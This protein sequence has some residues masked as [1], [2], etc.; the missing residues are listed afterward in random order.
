MPDANRPNIVLIHCHDL[1]TYLNCY[2]APTVRSPH[3]DALAAD[4][5]LFER[6]YCTA[7]QCSP[8]RASL[9]TGR[10]PHNNG[11]MGLTHAE[12]AWDFNPG[13]KHLATCLGE[14]GYQTI[15][16]GAT[17]EGRQ[18]PAAYGYQ[19]VIR[20]RWGN[21]VADAAT[22]RLAELAENPPDAPFYLY[23]GFMEPHRLPSGK[24]GELPGDHT[25]LHPEADYGPDTEL[26]VDVPG[27]L[28]DTPGTREE[29]AEL[30]A[31]I[32]W[33]DGQIGRILD[34]VRQSSLND[35]TLVVFT[36]DHGYAMPRAK[37]SLYDPGIAIALMM[38]LPSREG[39]HGGRRVGPMISNIDVM[40]TLLD[41]LGLPV[42]DGVQGV[43][44]RPL[45]DAEND[46]VPRETF[47]GE[48]T[49]HDYYDPK[50]CI[51]TDRYKLIANFST[52]PFFM[53]P[54]QMW[55][56]RSDTVVPENHAASYHS[57]I[58]FYDL[59]KD[60]WELE[61]LA[62]AEDVA[63]IRTDLMGRLYEHMVDTSDPILQGA[64]ACPQ[65]H[66]TQAMLEAAGGC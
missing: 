42:P 52:A 36:T 8:S 64:V 37:C 31:M 65:H 6:S 24:G 40:P 3:L 9:F 18:G 55:R 43:S 7:P 35:N 38:R 41:L 47:F 20:A 49:Y 5:V 53:D 17:H 57:Y 25:F 63:D 39:W 58:E 29:L 51:R 2:G 4:G 14:A 28:K 19:E 44:F 33:V 59:E 23:A 50:R 22:E 62:D 11:V 27:F 16:V 66:T 34:A 21:A 12:F 15:C 61:N 13:E 56:P 48:L 1:G 45:L 10:Y 54:S 60:P 32:H 30:Q 46:I 26:G